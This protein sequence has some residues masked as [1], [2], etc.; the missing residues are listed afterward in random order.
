MNDFELIIREDQTYAKR[1]SEYISTKLNVENI[2]ICSDNETLINELGNLKYEDAA[3]LIINDK[4]KQTDVI[5]KYEN[6]EILFLDESI[7]YSDDRNK[8]Y[9]YQ[10]AGAL[11]VDI[12][13]K[14]KLL[15]NRSDVSA[16]DVRRLI[17]NDKVINN[18][19]IGDKKIYGVYSPEGKSC[20]TS[21][22]ISLGELLSEKDKTL[23]IN[24]EGYSGMF[25]RERKKN[26]C[27]T[28]ANAIYDFISD[29]DRCA[30][31]IEKNVFIR[32]GLAYLY[33]SGQMELL[34]IEADIWVEFIS[35]I[36]KSTIYKN[37]VIDLGNCIRGFDKIMKKCSKVFMPSVYRKT[38]GTSLK[39]EEF[40]TDCDVHDI[41]LYPGGNLREVYIPNI[42]DINMTG[43]GIRSRQLMNYIDK[44]GLL[45]T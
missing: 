32:N 39:I 23:Y 11:L 31:N 13:N 5:K 43:Y 2:S 44:E 4:Y 8:V 22:A 15:K 17:R 20:K 33:P 34:E 40:K 9:K 1:L 3:L 16:G 42:S 28:V 45:L 21:F 37:V 41:L 12:Y 27:Y 24:L 7:N 35:F 6:V 19:D 26:N 10:P 29:E 38:D 25:L 18:Y 30:I 36:I 14:S